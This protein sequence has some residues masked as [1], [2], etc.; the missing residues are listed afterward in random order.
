MSLY[1]VDSLFVSLIL[2][3][4]FRGATVTS[5]F[6]LKEHTLLKLLRLGWLCF[7]RCLALQFQNPIHQFHSLY[8][9]LPTLPL[10]NG[11][12]IEVSGLLNLAGLKLSGFFLR[13]CPG[14]L[15]CL[16]PR[17]PTSAASA[18][19]HLVLSPISKTRERTRCQRKGRI[20]AV[21]WIGKPVH[22]AP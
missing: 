18:P 21:V 9:R 10:F 2:I 1:G 13:N 8:S 22:E 7:L 4:S 17:I 5:L 11:I 19:L 3:V 20:H 12:L 14:A 6:E 16:C 15:R